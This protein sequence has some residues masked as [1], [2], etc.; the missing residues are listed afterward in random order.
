MTQ[1]CRN[2][3]TARVSDEGPLKDIASSLYFCPTALASE[4]ILQLPWVW[5]D[6]LSVS[7]PVAQG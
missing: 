7:G 6:S 2:D 5:A 4:I 1:C 3:R